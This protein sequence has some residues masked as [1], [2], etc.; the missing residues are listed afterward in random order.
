MTRAEILHGVDLLLEERERYLY[1]HRRKLHRVEVLKGPLALLALTGWFV[2]TSDLPVLIVGAVATIAL[3]GVGLHIAGTLWA[4]RE[5]LEAERLMQR[6]HARLM[7]P[8]T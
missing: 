2:G 7:E 6:A 8:P 5:L 3:I 1:R 4:A